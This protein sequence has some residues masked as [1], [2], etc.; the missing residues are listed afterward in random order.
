MSLSNT[1][2]HHVQALVTNEDT[3]KN[4]KVFVKDSSFTNKTDFPKEIIH[5]FTQD[6]YSIV[7]DRAPAT[8]K[9]DIYHSI[10]N[11]GGT[12]GRPDKKLVGL[13]GSGPEST[14]FV[15]DK[16]AVP[17]KLQ[18]YCLLNNAIKA[19]AYHAVMKTTAAPARNCHTFHN[20]NI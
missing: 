12:R 1:W 10:I 3:N 9:L 2:K 20:A 5:K 6:K 13:L 8:N 18:F 11:L 19:I 7:L 17:N 16:F 14:A 15:F 4:L